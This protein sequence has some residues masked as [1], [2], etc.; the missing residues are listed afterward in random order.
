[1]YYNLP[2]ISSN[3]PA[4]FELS[5][6]FINNNDNINDYALVDYGL[7][8][9]KSSNNNLL[10]AIDYLVSNNEQYNKIKLNLKNKKSKFLME[11]N[12]KYLNVINSINI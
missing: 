11:N 1:M 6:S 7:I 9:N 2:I 5:D 8:F 12:L 10:K 4:A 3:I